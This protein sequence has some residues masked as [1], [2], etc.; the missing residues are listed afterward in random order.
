MLKKILCL[1]LAVTMVVG[2]LALTSC[3]QVKQ[4]QLD[5]RLPM[6]ISVLGITTEETT[7]EAVEA[8]EKAINDILGMTYNI[9]DIQY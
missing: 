4:N 2:V 5:E 1:V 7:D 9:D 3:G 6:T 8:V